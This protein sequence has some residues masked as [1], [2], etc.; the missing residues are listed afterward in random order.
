MKIIVPTLEKNIEG[1]ICESFG[2]TPVF[3]VWD[4]GNKD[5][6][7]FTND[8]AASNGGAG[9]KAAQAV[10]DQKADA[11]I[12]PRIGKNAS[13][14]LDLAGIKIYKSKTSDIM[15]NIH[16][17]EAGELEILTDIHPGFHNH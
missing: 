10:V 5:A 14:V 8:A 17:L 16:G 13:D 9:V 2:R 3:M 12:V 6:K 15:E 11:V 7:Y 1:G 4:T